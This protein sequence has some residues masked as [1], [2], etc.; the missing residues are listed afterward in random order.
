MKF[1]NRV[2][3]GDF[4]IKIRTERCRNCEQSNGDADYRARIDLQTQ[5]VFFISLHAFLQ[6]AHNYFTVLT[7]VC[8]AG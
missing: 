8:V 5:K 7:L 6:V 4:N 3:N 1:L 2:L